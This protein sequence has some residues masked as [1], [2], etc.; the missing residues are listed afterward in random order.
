LFTFLHEID[1]F[2]VKTDE[3]K[4]KIRL[5]FCI[6]VTIH[7]L[8]HYLRRLCNVGRICSNVISPVSKDGLPEGGQLFEIAVFGEVVT[9]MTMGS[10]YVISEIS[11]WESQETFSLKWNERNS[12]SKEL[13]LKGMSKDGAS[14]YLRFLSCSRE[15]IDKMLYFKL[16]NI[17]TLLYN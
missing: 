16:T 17:K 4:A 10:I 12:L 5:A 8:G 11:N 6:V 7:E 15:G 9:T 14:A 2:L 13:M 1:G 3:E